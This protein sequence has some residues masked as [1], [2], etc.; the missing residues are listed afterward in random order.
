MPNNFRLL[1]LNVLQLN[2]ANDPNNETQ[3]RKFMTT[4]F[5]YVVMAFSNEK[6]ERLSFL[7]EL[8]SRR[9]LRLSTADRGRWTVECR[10][11]TACS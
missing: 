1:R 11:W 7:L 2:F 4:R 6:R 5:Q 10:L 9:F 8:N 3:A